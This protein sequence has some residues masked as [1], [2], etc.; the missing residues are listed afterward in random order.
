MSKTI[1]VK[2]ALAINSEG[3]WHAYGYKGC[4]VWNE[5]MDGFDM[6]DDEHKRWITADVILP[7]VEPDVIGGLP[8]AVS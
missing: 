6:L 8:E 3:E 2:I 4:D 7:E 5:A 1:K